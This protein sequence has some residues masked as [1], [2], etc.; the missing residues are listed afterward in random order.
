MQYLGIPRHM[1]S[2]LAYETLIENF[3]VFQFKFSF[4]ENVVVLPYCDKQ[5][6]Y[7]AL[8]LSMLGPD[9]LYLNSTHILNSN[10]TVSEFCLFEQHLYH[11]SI[12]LG[13]GHMLRGGVFI[14]LT[15]KLCPSENEQTTALLVVMSG[16]EVKRSHLLFVCG[17][18]R[19]EWDTKNVHF[20]IHDQMSRGKLTIECSQASKPFVVLFMIP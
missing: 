5:P 7:P 9:Y 14:I 3:G 8:A 15:P 6:C 18:N 2:T 20:L 13:G 17:L 4:G 1:Q 11:I 16:C 19:K 12:T 10:P